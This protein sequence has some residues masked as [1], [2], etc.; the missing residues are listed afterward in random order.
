MLEKVN[1]LR[2]FLR[3]KRYKV[4]DDQIQADEI[5][6]ALKA[7]KVMVC[8]ITAAYDASPDCRNELSTAV[9]EL[10]LPLIVIMFDSE[11]KKTTGLEQLNFASYYVSKLHRLYVPK[12]VVIDWKEDKLIK[13]KIALLVENAV[14]FL[15]FAYDHIHEQIRLRLSEKLTTEGYH[16]KLPTCGV[17][18]FPSK[19]ITTT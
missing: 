9:N 16:K 7:S 8:W 4:S 1:G 11:Q 18:I 6:K 14:A 19:T 15:E 5:S 12:D 13:D 3:S 17:T 10:K 2:D